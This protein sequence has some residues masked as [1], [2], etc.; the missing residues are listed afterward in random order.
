[1]FSGGLSTLSRLLGRSPELS[2]SP[3]DFFRRSLHLYLRSA[4][5]SLYD[6]FISPIGHI[7]IY[8]FCLVFFPRW[9]TAFSRP[10]EWSMHLTGSPPLLPGRLVPLIRA[11]VGFIPF[12]SFLALLF[13]FFCR[14]FPC[15]GSRFWLLGALF[16]RVWQHEATLLSRGSS[17]VVAFLRSG[18]FRARANANQPEPRERTHTKE[19][20]SRKATEGNP[21]TGLCCVQ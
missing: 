19:D 8:K 12:F 11:D 9:N 7:Y 16:L 14:L 3:T 10:G 20:R 18:P 6:I 17:L 2:L 15:F 21:P 1:M 4:Y 13:V 5:M